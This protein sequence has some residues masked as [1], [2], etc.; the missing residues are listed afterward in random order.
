MKPHPLAKRYAKALY[1]LADEQQ[2]VKTVYDEV[3]SFGSLFE[4]NNQFRNFLCSPEIETRKKLKIVEQLLKDSSPLF[5]NFMVLLV[6][7]GRQTL[8]SH[9]VFEM[10]RIFDQRNNRIRAQLTTAIALPAEKSKEIQSML[11][12][13]FG[14]QVLLETIVDPDLL[15]GMVIRAEGRV[16]DAS[17]RSQVRALTRSMYQSKMSA[18]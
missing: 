17:L 5:Y 4:Q 13:R 8:F 12:K 14:S 2:T 10:G 6:K 18:V 11:S 16:L 15:G 9:I 1:E 3:N 7:K